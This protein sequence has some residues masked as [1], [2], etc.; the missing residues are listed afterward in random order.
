MN[1]LQTPVREPSLLNA[2]IKLII[3][4]V[5]FFFYSIRHLFQYYLEKWQLYWLHWHNVHHQN[6]LYSPYY[7]CSLVADS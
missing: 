2:E 5:F 4:K 1:N 6:P 3:F 7:N